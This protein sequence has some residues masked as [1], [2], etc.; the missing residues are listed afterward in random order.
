MTRHVLPNVMPLVLANTTL[1]VAVAILTETTLS[2]LGLGDPLSP[3]WG[4][5]LER[6]YSGGAISGG[7]W[8]WIFA[9]GFSVVLTV[10]AF[11][12]CGRA[13]ERILD[14]RLKGI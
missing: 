9:P 11:N 7:F 5:I 6:A 14:P 4:H 1:T 12:L 8:W 10:L 2:F 3:S 13:M